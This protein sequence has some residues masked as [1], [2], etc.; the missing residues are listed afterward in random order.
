MANTTIYPYGTN[1]QL[2]SSIGVINDLTTGGA[3][4][5]LSAEQGKDIKSN[6]LNALDEITIPESVETTEVSSFVSGQ[7]YITYNVSVGNTFS[8]S[9]NNNSSCRRVAVSFVSGDVLRVWGKGSGTANVWVLVDANNVVKAKSNTNSGGG[10]VNPSTSITETNPAVLTP[11]YNGK[12]YFTSDTSVSNGVTVQHTTPAYLITADSENNG[13][14][15]KELASELDEDFFSLLDDI[16][17]VPYTDTIEFSLTTSS[18]IYNNYQKG[19]VGSTW[20][21]E[22]EGYGGVKCGKIAIKKGDV[23]S[24]WG[25]GSGI[26]SLYAITDNEHT[27]I[28]RG[29][30]G[31]GTY[32][33]VVTQSSPVVKTIL[34]DGWLYMNSLTGNDAGAEISRTYSGAK[35]ANASQDGLMTKEYAAIV[36]GLGNSEGGYAGKAIA[37]LGDSFSATGGWINK[38]SSVLG[39]RQAINKAISGGAWHG[40]DSLST[41]AKARELY[42]GYNGAASPDVILIFLGVNDY[43]NSVTVGDINY[44][45]L[46]TQKDGNNLLSESTIASNIS[47]H[48]SLSGGEFTAGVQSTLAYLITMYPNALIKI[49]WTPN[50]QQ[51]M[52]ASW[53]WSKLNGYLNR[54]KELA[55]MYG[56]QYLDTFNCGICAWMYDH[57]DIYQTGGA[58]GDAH[59]SSAAH[60]RTGEYIAR[61]LLSNL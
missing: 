8:G 18:A 31:E 19:A 61:L 11:D 25:A 46:G 9:F 4:K 12:L 10:G 58:S 13:L 6:Y 51:Y 23:I 39:L 3:D 50:G 29:Y 45:S 40:N 1:G 32:P 5:A 24:I 42:S 41:F 54:L 20:N 43:G 21:P 22:A 2:P 14:M 30:G 59:P 53:N 44:N 36:D 15:P 16:K 60:T 26:G 35:R 56:V 27:V 7:Q 57:R 52:R 17:Q 55:L 47:T 48:Y 34:Y 37:V 28:A 33:S 49:G 38:M